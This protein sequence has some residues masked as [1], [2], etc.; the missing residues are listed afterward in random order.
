MDGASKIQNGSRDVTTPFHGRFVVRRLGLA[1]VNLCAKFEVS[2]FTHYEDMNGS[3]KCRNWGGF[4][5]PKV[6]SSIT[7]R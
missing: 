6:I 2:M 4:G 7:I 1:T 5:L 3:E